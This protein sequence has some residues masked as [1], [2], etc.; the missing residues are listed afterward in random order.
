MDM[1]TVHPSAWFS[2]SDFDGLGKEMTI[3]NV[4][5]QQVGA[6]FKPVMY[7]NGQEKGL[8]LNPT[9]NKLIIA[10]LG[11]ESKDWTGQKI[12]LFSYT[13]MFQGQPQL[14]IGVRPPDGKAIAATPTPV[15]QYAQPAQ[16]LKDEMNDEIPF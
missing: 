10:M 16:P 7:F 13:A 8:V 12:V 4:M 11:W 5:M 1:R 6:E 9:N 3:G 15:R 14:R 2:A